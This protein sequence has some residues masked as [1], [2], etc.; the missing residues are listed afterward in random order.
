MEIRKKLE[1]VPKQELSYIFV[2]VATECVSSDHNMV[3][4]KHKLCGLTEVTAFL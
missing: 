1:Q 4:D 2:F 3:E